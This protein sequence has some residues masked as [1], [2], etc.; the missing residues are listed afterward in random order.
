M[1]D[2]TRR[3]F[4]EGAAL[5]MGAALAPAPLLATPA[6]ATRE[7]ADDAWHRAPCEM[8]G[9]A[10]GLLV[11]LRSGRAAA[12]KG[13]PDCPIAQGLA[14]ARGYFG[15]QTLYGA[16]RRTTAMV[17]RGGTLVPAPL[18]VAFDTV[19][20]ALRDTVSKYHRGAA[21][22][23]STPGATASSVALRAAYGPAA[24]VASFDD[25]DR[26][27]VVVLWHHNLAES[28]PVLF[29]RLVARRRRN[30]GLRIVD[31]GT[32][33]TRTSYAADRALRCAP[34]SALALANA[35]AQ[36]LIGTHGA[37]ERVLA[38]GAAF[39]AGT[40]QPASR[41]QYEGFLREYQPERM[42]QV[43]GLPTDAIRWLA[44]LY[45]DRTR[46]VVS[47]WGT[48][49]DQQPHGAWVNESVHAL[50]ILRGH[51]GRAGEGVLPLAAPPAATV[52]GAPRAASLLA[53]FR[54]V[55]R[56]STRFLWVQDAD[57]LAILPNAERYRRAAQRDCFV[58]LSSAYP[59]RSDEI[60]DVIL[61]SA[62][63]IER[64]ARI[65]RA[66]GSTTMVPVL[67]APPGDATSARGQRVAVARLAGAA[68]PF[69]AQA[70][71]S[72]V[73]LAG[74]PG[75]PGVPGV[76]PSGVV[77]SGDDAASRAS[78]GERGAQGW[79]WMRPQLPPAERPDA[80]YP[81]WLERGDVLEHGASGAATMQVPALRRAMPGAY[82]EMHRDDAIALGLRDR[83]RVRLVSRRGTIELPLRL[84]YRSQPARGRVFVPTFDPTVPVNQLALDS[85]CPDSGEP[86]YACA[87]RVERIGNGGRA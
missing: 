34:G 73:A 84:D 83:D 35:L 61:P 24:P 31:V 82:V 75:R 20:R 14:C 40:G 26:A 64:E 87:V 51:A 62:L 52:D 50:H 77:S 42:E 80:Q 37:D 3:A 6:P 7:P 30:P 33:T 23:L 49:L 10:C 43:T 81:L 4:L 59:G 1:A 44:S 48:E 16:N 47:V 22:L 74:S 85:T 54:A 38:T 46:R 76:V 72:A 19:A 66:D 36:A 18:D 57:P 32:R 8:C 25:L 27:D 41:R 53:A 68:W 12:V 69:G 9:V 86:D 5:S 15:L 45:A 13:D 21:T 79:L 65:G 11:Q 70:A 78:L 17:R 63:W 60:A 28:H 58:V 67:L 29:S 71:A 39:R 56:G 55:E 2:L